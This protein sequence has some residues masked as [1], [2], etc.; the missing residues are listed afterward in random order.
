MMD[1]ERTFLV[2]SAWFDTYDEEIDERHH[3]YDEFGYKQSYEQPE[4][5]EETMTVSIYAE[6]NVD[7]DILTDQIADALSDSTGFCVYHFMF[8][9]VGLDG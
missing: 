1:K 2:E 4:F 7:A 3:F 6:E 5:D 9:E 8:S